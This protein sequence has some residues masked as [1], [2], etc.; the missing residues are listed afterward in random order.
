MTKPTLVVTSRYPKEIE[1]RIDRDFNARRNSNQFPFSQQQLLSAADG[2]DAMFIAPADRLDSGFFQKVSRTIKIIATFSVGS[3]HIDL[4]AAARRK[5]PVAYTPGVNQEATADIAMLLLLGASRRAYEAQELVRTGTWSPLSPDML[6][7]WQIG[8]KILGIFGMGRAEILPLDPWAPSKAGAF[9]PEKKHPLARLFIQRCEANGIGR[10]PSSNEL[11]FA[12]LESRMFQERP[13]LTIRCFRAQE[14][15][16]RRTGRNFLPK[17]VGVYSTLT[18]I[19]ANISL[20]TSPSLSSSRNCCVS[21]FCEIR[22][23]LSRRPLNRR[24]SSLLRSHQRITGF[25]RPPI[26]TSSS[27]IGHLLAIR[28]A[29]IDLK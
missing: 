14:S 28:L 27:S 1:D 7:G 22:G 3:E 18:G 2:A 8:G 29:L 12:T 6:L 19:S 24:G 15:S 9:V 17:G 16:A 10:L 20:L 23:I 11:P 5:I 13:F 26:S 25:H 21:T 4:E